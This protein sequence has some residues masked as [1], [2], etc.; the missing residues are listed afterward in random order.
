M[1]NA[2]LQIGINAP[3]A[4]E[5]NRLAGELE[6]WLKDRVEDL[7][8]Q[9]AKENP[10]TQDMGTLLV[11]VLSSPAVVALASEPAKALAEGIADW[12]RKR[13]VNLSIGADGSVTA[14]NVRADDVERIIQDTLKAQ[15]A[16]GGHG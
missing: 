4:A 12:L 5:S 1:G 6:K 14:E 9:R 8:I 3:S 15:A 11:A 7:Q 16:R 2:S 10:E 13:R